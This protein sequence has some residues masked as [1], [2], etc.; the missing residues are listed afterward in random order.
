MRAGFSLV[1]ALSV[2][3]VGGFAEELANVK[4][5]DSRDLLIAD[6]GV[7]K[8]GIDRAMGA[9]ITHLSWSGYERNT[10][11]IHD[12]GRLIQQSYYA[13]EKI[14][15][16][17][18]GQNQAWSPWTWNPIQ[19][20]GVGSWARVTTFEKQESGSLY[21]ET[22]PKLW[23]M[24]DE[25]AAAVMRQ[26]TGFERGLKNAVLVECELESQ[27]DVEDQWG[28]G[29]PRHQEIPA[30][31]FTRNFSEFR[32]YRGKGEWD[33]VPQ[34]PGPPWGRTEVPLNIMACFNERGQGIAVFSP[35]ATEQWNFGPHREGNSDESTA[36]PCV[37][38]APLVT[39]RLE[40]KSVLQYRYWI[41][42]GAAEEIVPTI[43]A[44]LELYSGENVVL[45]NP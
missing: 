19:G 7:V 40:P 9:S 5:L 45:I 37:H 27:R 33:N 22:I 32:I 21:A 17:N 4:A 23:D 24:P 8:V 41:V 16:Q 34:S 14:D 39:V 38:L 44:L 12:P 43:E 18:Q 28:G 42:V 36:G 13:G 2:V 26:R 11:N 29:R 10:V 6:N 35:S 30:L 1:V 31:Y 20:G 15:R 3:C 25:E